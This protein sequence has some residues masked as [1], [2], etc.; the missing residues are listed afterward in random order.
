MGF[1]ACGAGPNGFCGGGGSL[2]KHRRITLGKQLCVW[3]MPFVF[4]ERTANMVC[5][6]ITQCGFSLQ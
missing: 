2:Y 4:R 5:T 6:I 1:G 3:E